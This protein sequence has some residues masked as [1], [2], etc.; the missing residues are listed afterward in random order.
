MEWVIVHNDLRDAIDAA[1]DV[2]LAGRP[3]DDD[4]RE[5]IFRRLLGYYD[6]HGRIPDFTLTGH[7]HVS[8]KN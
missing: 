2:A 7:C 4:G 1:I 5:D 6:D 3:C 8:Q